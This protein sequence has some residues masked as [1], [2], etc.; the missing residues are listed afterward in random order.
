MTVQAQSWDYLVVTASNNGQAAAYEE[1]L[2]L[3]RELGFL[4]D[5]RAVLVVPDP[6]GKRVGSGGS[7]IHC[8]LTVL[9]RELEDNGH[10]ASDPAEWEALL[11]RL[12]ILIVHAGGDSKRL[13]AY[14]PCGKIFIPLPGEIE[15]ALG[16]T[17]F[18]EQIPTYLALPEPSNGSGQVVI[19]SGDVLLGF[20]PAQ[21][22]FASPGI[23]GLGCH[24]APEQA[25][26]HGV[27]CAASDGDVRR[28]LQKPAPEEQARQGAVDRYGRTILDIGVMSFDPATALALLGLCNATLDDG[29]LAWSGS[30][31]QV[32]LDRGL[33]FYCEVAC[34]LG[35]QTTR[36]DH[37]SSARAS[38]STWADDDLARVFDALAPLPFHVQV[39]SHCSFLH[40]GAAHQLISSGSDLL[41]QKRGGARHGDCLSINNEIG[42]DGRIR[43]EDAW[44]EGCRINSVLELGLG[45]V[46]AGVDV[47]Q[48]LSLP[49]QACLGVS[50]GRNRQDEPVWFVRCYCATDDFKG[51]IQHGAA[52]WGLPVAEL[53][54]V[55]NAEPETIWADVPAGERTL[56]NARVFPAETAPKNYRNWLWLLDPRE[57]DNNQ[58]SAWRSADRYSF[59]EIARLTC[60]E[61]FYERRTRI[62]AALVLEAL[63]RLLRPDSP[64]SAGELALAIANGDDVPSWLAALTQEARKYNDRDVTGSALDALGF[65]RV[66]HTT[67]TALELLEAER[68]GWVNHAAAGFGATARQADQDW[69]ATI[70]LEFA[71]ERKPAWPERAKDLAFGSLGDA[72]TSSTARL[73]ALPKNALRKD[74]I[75]WGRAPARLDLGGGWSDT[76]PYTLER[77]GC[78]INAAI[79]LNGQPP[80]QA[81]ARVIDEPVIR[82]ASIDFG[83]RVEIHDLED[84]LDYH[85]VISGF[86]LPKAALALAAF[87]PEA[88]P[89][90]DGTTLE[91]MLETF[92]GG[93]ELT[94][95]AAIPGGSGLGTSSI[96]GAVILAVVRRILG[97]PIEH[98]ELFHEVLRLEQAL[99]TGGGWQDQIGGVVDG[100]KIITTQPGL[101]PDPSIHYVLPDVLDPHT[102]GGQT[103]LYYT[104][105]TRLAKNILQKVVGRYLDRDRAAMASLRRI[106]AFPPRVAD[107]M[108]RKDSVSFGH[109]IAAAW[110]LK[111]AIDPHSTNP[112][113]EAL[114]ERVR[115]YV[116]GAKLMGAGGGGFLLL[117]CNSPHDAA[118][119]RAE[120]E[121][122][123]ANDRSR[124]F[125]FSVSTEGLVV[126][127]C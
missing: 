3:R 32:I 109:A 122:N 81:Y 113:I 11:N 68:P 48:P 123:A 87:S 57:A 55:A 17:L 91:Q 39:L 43:G 60:Q 56:W 18:D 44:V 4:S 28:F 95:L 16:T 84:L 66:T 1:Q 22:S 13:P 8:L 115:P 88:A 77:G 54:G 78:V 102:N 79:N 46:L 29:Q 45:S 85:D 112:E 30:I 31:G 99:T 52:L 72:I 126:T 12:R 6:A 101:L 36:A 42:P 127:V 41:R 53:P 38:G 110:E 26:N 19:T 97:T 124:L 92:G 108:A 111:K 35:S 89:W 33:D 61:P 69:L 118:T 2:R 125:D 74:E 15:S 71:S 50:E 49:D 58:W 9:N 73:D 63:P 93:I 25:R 104:G 40:F 34:A 24:A 100:V 21:V 103:L 98:R 14:G 23:T 76:P 83:Q 96:V 106:H 114:L 10:S 62:R 75:V 82:L 20:D 59:E 64:F 5:V 121:S 105:I 51:T 116:C 119:L 107:A 120:L 47:D 37:A 80:I 117:V 7:T 27:Y 90:P 94:T 86:S 70:G 65:S 67:A